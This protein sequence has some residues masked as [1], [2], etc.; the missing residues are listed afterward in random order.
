MLHMMRQRISFMVAEYAITS[1]D[2][3]YTDPRHA[4]TYFPVA[5]KIRDYANELGSFNKPRDQWF[6][7]S[8]VDTAVALLTG[9]VGLIREDAWPDLGVLEGDTFTAEDAWPWGP[10]TFVGAPERNTATGTV[11]MVIAILHDF[12]DAQVKAVNQRVWAKPVE[13]APAVV[14]AVPVPEPVAA[15]EDAEPVKVRVIGTG[16]AVI[17]GPGFQGGVRRDPAKPRG[18]YEVLAFGETADQAT[19]IGRATSYAKAGEV[20]AAHHGKP[21]LSVVVSRKPEAA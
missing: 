15:V 12:T 5:V 18:A 1:W 2:A 10:H 19:V 21:D 20:L 9:E 3:G 8:V 6:P 11:R 7:A 13:A 14:E 17:I 4:P 16:S